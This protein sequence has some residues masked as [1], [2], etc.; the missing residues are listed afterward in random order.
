MTTVWSPQYEY[1]ARVVGPEMNNLTVRGTTSPYTVKN[2]GRRYGCTSVSYK[3]V[4]V[5]R[6]ARDAKGNWRQ[7]RIPS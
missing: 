2:H 7:A 1:R 3:L 6:L 5:L 4:H